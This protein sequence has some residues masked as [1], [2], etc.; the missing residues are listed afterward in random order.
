MPAPAGSGKADRHLTAE[1]AVLGPLH[2]RQGNSWMDVER[3]PQ[4]VQFGQHGL[5]ARIIQEGLG[6]SPDERSAL[7]AQVLD[8]SLQLF[9]RFM[10]VLP[11]GAPQ[12]RQTGWD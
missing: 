5:V 10:R 6:W 4:L 3:H 9:G 7:E 2:L 11:A 8:G 12:S 1:T